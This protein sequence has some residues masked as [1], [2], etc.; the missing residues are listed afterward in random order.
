[1]QVFV[2]I[3]NVGVKIIAGVNVKNW[4]IKAVVI[5][6]LFGILVIV[7]CD[8]P[9]DVGEYL[10][11]SNCKCRKKL[12][13]KVVE[14]CIVDKGVVPPISRPTP[15]PP[16]FLRYPLSRNPRCPHLS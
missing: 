14:E 1:M 16:P 15:P 3:N 5:K 12:V 13:H 4:L 10:D 2:I 6:D 9:C 8:E 11:Y 7:E